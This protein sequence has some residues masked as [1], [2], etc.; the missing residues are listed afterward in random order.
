MVI[1]TDPAVQ[2][3]QY[4][5]RLKWQNWAHLGR[6]RPG[7]EDLYDWR[8]DS[9]TLERL[10]PLYE[11]ARSKLIRVIGRPSKADVAARHPNPFE[12]EGLSDDARRLIRDLKAVFGPDI[13]R[14]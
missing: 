11:R 12:D 5:N 3:G 10:R 4:E 6:E 8:R 2:Q 1:S 9:E 14:D 7:A 13:L